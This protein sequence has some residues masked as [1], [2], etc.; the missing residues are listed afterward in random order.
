MRAD[1]EVKV[2]GIYCTTSLQKYDFKTINSNELF[3][4]SALRNLYLLGSRVQM[5]CCL[6]VETEFVA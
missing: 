6:A 2:T 4:L 3:Y 5:Q 1:N